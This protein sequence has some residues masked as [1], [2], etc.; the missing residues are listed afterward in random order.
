MNQ[1]NPISPALKSMALSI[2]ELRISYTQIFCRGCEWRLEGEG[3][4]AEGIVEARNHSQAS[5]HKT[6]VRM[7]DSIVFAPEEEM[8][9]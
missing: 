6:T 8:M 9:P 5:G 3:K 2:R 4:I 1:S 7:I